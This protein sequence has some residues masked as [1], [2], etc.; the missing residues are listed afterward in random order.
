MWC[1]LH[2]GAQCDGFFHQFGPAR[3]GF[4]ELVIHW[5]A[6]GNEGF[7]VR[8][9]HFHSRVSDFSSNSLSSRAAVSY[10]KGCTSFAVCIRMSC[11]SCGSDSSLRLPAVRYAGVYT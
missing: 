8:L 2:V 9:V 4:T 1:G 6:G 10:T 3:D 7:F 5:T 11:T